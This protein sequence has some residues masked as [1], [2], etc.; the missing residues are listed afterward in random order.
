VEE[1]DRKFRRQVLSSTSTDRYVRRV[2]AT[3]R[4]EGRLH[5]SYLIFTSDNGVH[6]G[7]HRL[8]SGKNTPYVTDTRVPLAIR[9][10]G[11]EPG[12]VVHE[13][14]GNID[15]A[16]TI[17]DMANV[18]LG[19]RHDG[20]SLL[21]LAKGRTPDRWREHLLVR[22]G[23]SGGSAP[24]RAPA[25]RGV[26]SEDWQYV[27]Y[28]TEEE[29]LYQRAADPFQLLNLMSLPE[30]ERTAEQQEAL[31]ASRQALRRLSRCQGV[32]DC[33]R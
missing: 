3:L 27:R 14:A 2:V 28:G 13:V 12:T 7:A 15:L 25:F 21:P 6:L 24:G 32:V 23:G 33:R 5:D 11:I 1:I 30:E 9:G 16:S 20:E 31:S 8:R 18:R 22:R 17:A 4:S 29:E 10:P 19:F 26:I